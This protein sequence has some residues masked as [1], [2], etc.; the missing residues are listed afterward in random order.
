MKPPKDIQLE[1]WEQE[2]LDAIENGE[3]ESIPDFEKA[4]AEYEKMAEYTLK[5]M[6]T[7]RPATKDDTGFARETH[8]GA[9]RD[10][11]K[12]QFGEWNNVEQ[13]WFFDE[14]WDYKTHEI[15][16]FRGEPCGYIYQEVQLNDVHIHE[17]VIHPKF[18][19][20]GIGSRILRNIIKLAESKNFPVLL[21]TFHANRAIGLYKKFG[22]KEYKRTQTHILLRRNP[23]EKMSESSL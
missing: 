15:I 6:I 23:K 1:P 16:L 18:Q 5:N 14:S 7:M 8:H 19:S 12:K 22:F 3:F 20:R 9:Y 13:D 2:I 17:L 11:V 10:V 4:K 21:Q